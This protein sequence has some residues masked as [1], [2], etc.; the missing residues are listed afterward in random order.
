M[1]ANARA[2]LMKILHSKHTPALHRVLS[3]QLLVYEKCFGCPNAS[4]TS[5]LSVH[6]VTRVDNLGAIAPENAAGPGGAK[7]RNSRIKKTELPVF[8]QL[9]LYHS[10]E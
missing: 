6:C 7:M 9:R 2:E 5:F 1:L 4:K 8:R 3:R 10:S